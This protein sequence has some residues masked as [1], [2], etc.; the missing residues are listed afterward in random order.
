MYYRNLIQSI[1]ADMGRQEVDPR[2]VEGWMR[3]ENPT[4][5][6]LDRA[7]FQS[8]VKIAVACID[9][10]EGDVSERLAQSYGL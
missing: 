2:H 6:H 10:P 9:G 8:E 1:L 7:T 5:D 4:L 3:C